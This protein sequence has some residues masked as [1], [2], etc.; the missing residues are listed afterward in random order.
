MG[1]S[2][3]TYLAVGRII[4]ALLEKLMH[5][6]IALFY[7][8]LYPFFVIVCGVLDNSGK[9]LFTSRSCPGTDKIAVVQSLCQL[10]GYIEIENKVVDILID[11]AYVKRI[12]AV[13][14]IRSF[15]VFLTVVIVRIVVYLKMSGVAFKGYIYY[16]A[17][18]GIICQRL[19]RMHYAHVVS[20]AVEYAAGYSVSEVKRF[21]GV[22]I[23][24]KPKR[25]AGK[26]LRDSVASDY[27]HVHVLAAPYAA[28]FERIQTFDGRFS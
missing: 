3:Y 22:G 28:F 25:L 24:N 8:F 13:L 14:V 20:L 23:G 2:Y 21:V 1:A 4:S 19:Y 27:P 17:R 18:L 5:D 7:R 15:W 10:S 26:L 16:I 12:E 6:L 11:H 9:Y